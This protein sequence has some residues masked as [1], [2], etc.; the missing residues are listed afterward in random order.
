MPKVRRSSSSSLNRS[1]ASPY[2]CTSEDADHY[3]LNSPLENTENLKEWEDTRCPICM[4]HPHN[5]VLIKCSSHE[6]GCMPY[7]CN[8]SYRHSNCLDQFCKSSVPDSTSMMLQELPLT[9]TASHSSRE[10]E[11]LPG[12][13]SPCGS[14]LQLHPACPLCRGK[15][16]G[17]IVV[18]AARHFMNFKVRSCSSETCDFSGNY[19]EL[20]KHARTE[21]PYVRPSEVDPDR[22]RDWMRLERQRDLE[23]VLSI[24]EVGTGDDIFPD[25]STESGLLASFL[26]AMYHSLELMFY[27]QWFDSSSDIEQTHSRSPGRM[28]RVQQNNYSV[29]ATRRNNTASDST[30]RSR[31]LLWRRDN[32]DLQMSRAPR[33]SNDSMSGETGHAPSR[34]SNNTLAED[35]RIRR[36]ANSFS[37]E[38]TNRVFRRGNNT[39]SG[40][41]PASTWGNNSVPEEGTRASRRDSNSVSEVSNRMHR[42]GN[43]WEEIRWGNSSLPVEA[44]DPRR[45]GDTSVPESTP[46][47]RGRRYRYYGGPTYHNRR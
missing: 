41:A 5:A 2:P 40:T 35:S 42:W 32:N 24:V 25:P 4:E 13:T 33:P 46:R 6:N 12:Q 29:S 8:T 36:R 1:R 14:Q 17:Y 45:W 16:Y 31:G 39:V 22:R 18:E 20:R 11:L 21:H 30:S 43:N 44:D 19:S 9:H 23:D 3:K 26:R 10:E 7:M 34:R 27:S 37:E 38:G 47:P 28:T 15:I